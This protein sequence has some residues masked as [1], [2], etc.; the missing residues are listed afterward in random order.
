[1]GSDVAGSR[2]Y[3]P[4]DDVDTIDWGASA[5]LSSARATDEFI[6]RERFAEEAPRIVAVCDRRP[7]MSLFPPGLP[8]LRKPDAMREAVELIAGSA[9]QARGFVGYLD[10]GDLD[11]PDPRRRTTEP[12]WH[13][14]R[15]QGGLWEV[16]EERLV[17][18]AFHA[19]Q[20]NLAQAF[21]HLFEV[22]RSV[23]PGTF[24]FVLSDFIVA[25]AVDVWLRALERR[26]D[27][28]P[29][30]IQDPVWEQSFPDVASLVVPLADAR[31]GRVSPVRLTRREAQERKL[32]HEG[33][34]E[35]IVREFE[36][37]GLE[38]VVIGSAER[39][40]VFRVLLSWAE[41]RA[42]RKGLGW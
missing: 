17:D 12:F 41:S 10:L 35:R 32:A 4:G 26:W 29:V 27:V 16:R 5:K 18:P 13:A 9:L 25:P 2:P 19:P 11:H 28:V 3:A 24:L 30:I 40:E 38:P 20:D 34:L 15:S 1:M 23:P 22:R 42:Y 33:R 36:A 31:T 39:E 21:D 37:L 8:W 6:V 7:E 14:P